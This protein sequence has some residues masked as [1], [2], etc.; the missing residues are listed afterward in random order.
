MTTRAINISLY[1]AED[2]YSDNLISKTEFNRIKEDLLVKVGPT[3][4][5]DEE[6]N[7]VYSLQAAKSKL[8]KARG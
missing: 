5:Y 3:H 4:E 1:K 8:F 7:Q 2:L 6:L